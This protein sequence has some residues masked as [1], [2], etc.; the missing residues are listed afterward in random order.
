MSAAIKGALYAL[1]LGALLALVPWPISRVLAIIPAI[2]IW[3][4]VTWASMRSIR[5]L[6]AGKP[7]FYEKHVSMIKKPNLFIDPRKLKQT[8]R[9]RA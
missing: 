6:R 4:G 2:F 9:N 1:I 8:E 5:K 3:L 7:M